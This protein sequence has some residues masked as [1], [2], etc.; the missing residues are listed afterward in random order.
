V[1]DAQALAELSRRHHDHYLE[2]RRGELAKV[3]GD[4]QR[5]MGHR[6]SLAS[7][8]AKRELAR[9]YR[10]EYLALLQPEPAPAPAMPERQPGARLGILTAD[11]RAELEAL[12]A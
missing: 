10:E 7:I 11:E 2:L 5:S 12:L 9:H 3:A 1:T 8:R 6:Q 4:G